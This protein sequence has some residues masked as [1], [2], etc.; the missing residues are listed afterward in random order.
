MY[1]F[2]NDYPTPDGTCIR[3]FIHVEDLAK[4]HV[5]ALKKLENMEHSNCEAYNLGRGSGYSVLQ[6]V[7]EY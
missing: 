7:E 6:I 2:G 5:A 3:D 1:V 4:G